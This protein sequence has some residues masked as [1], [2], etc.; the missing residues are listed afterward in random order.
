MNFLSLDANENE[1]TMF[2]LHLAKGTWVIVL[3]NSVVGATGYLFAY[4]F[5][6]LCIL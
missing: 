6:N 3:V 1:P 2:D 4:G 5:E